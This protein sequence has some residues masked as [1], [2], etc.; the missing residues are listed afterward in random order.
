MILSVAHA[1][2]AAITSRKYSAG[3][4]REAVPTR[5]L[6]TSPGIRESRSISAAS[7]EVSQNSRN[8][9]QNSSPRR[10]DS[11]LGRG[12]G[13]IR[14]SRKS[15][16]NSCLSKLG[17]V[18]PGLPGLPPQPGGLPAR[19][20]GGRV[21]PGP[22]SCSLLPIWPWPLRRGARPGNAGIVCYPSRPPGSGQGARPIRRCARPL[23]TGTGG[24]CRAGSGWRGAHAGSRV[25]VDLAG[26][27]A[28]A[29]CARRHKTRKLITEVAHLRTPP[30]MR[31]LRYGPDGHPH[32]AFSLSAVPVSWPLSRISAS[33]DR[34]D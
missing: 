28:H 19:S 6:T 26:Q 29:D 1:Q 31:G 11:S 13:W 34:V 23:V 2:S 5:R 32:N 27:L 17:R 18:Q 30:P 14:P 33:V 9:A 3:R 15:P 16:R 22:R 8:R 4:V 25:V 20:P 12:C 21:L 7:T 24:P 10:L